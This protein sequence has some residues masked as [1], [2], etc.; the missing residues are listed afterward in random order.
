MFLYLLMLTLMVT[1]SI[2]IS[3]TIIQQA[4]QK[5]RIGIYDARGFYLVMLVFITFV[6]TS[7]A[8][9]WGD[10]RFAPISDS[11]SEPLLGVLYSL[12][13]CLTGLAFGLIRLKGV[14][15]IE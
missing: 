6:V 4:L 15:P 11:L 12:L 7:V 3:F 2:S 8:F 10:M 14:D 13:C 1:G 9:F 5:G